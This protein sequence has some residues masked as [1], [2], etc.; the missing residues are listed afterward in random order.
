M[1]FSDSSVFVAISLLGVVGLFSYLLFIQRRRSSH[2]QT[3]ITELA[4]L[5]TNYEP[6]SNQ[7]AGSTFLVLVNPM[8]GKKDGREIFTN[9]ISPF[10]HKA[11]V[12]CELIVTESEHHIRE[13][14]E[15]KDFSPYSAVLVVSGDGMLCQM[16]NGF[17]KRFP[18][19]NGNGAARIHAE[20]NF[21]AFLKKTPIGVIPCGTSNGMAASLTGSTPVE[22]VRSILEGTVKPVDLMRVGDRHWDT[23]VFAWGAT[24]DFDVIVEGKLRWMGPLRSNLAAMLV[25]LRDRR[26]SGQIFFRP[27]EMS[28]EKRTELGYSDPDEVPFVTKCGFTILDGSHNDWRKIENDYFAVCAGNVSRGATDMIFSHHLKP[29]E[30]AV[31]LMVIRWDENSRLDLLKMFLAFETGGHISMAGVEM[32]K[33]RELLVL[34]YCA[35][36]DMTIS[37]EQIES[38]ATHVTVK[39]GWARFVY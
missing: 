9:V 38:G 4:E 14:S 20:E 29:D 19:L 35:R 1:E 15:F 33:V 25:I 39:N 16:F 24:A 7:W 17:A 27:I 34:P 10:C 23:H 6:H 36:S 30:G 5:L 28:S 8:S 3:Q 32:Y 37:G 13:I 26:V 18:D 22:S 2:H 11:N 31:D 12:T 21:Q